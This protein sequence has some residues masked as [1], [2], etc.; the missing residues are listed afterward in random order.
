M[1]QIETGN[2]STTS[3]D[4]GGPY[5]WKYT[6]PAKIGLM[7]VHDYYYS[8]KGEETTNCYSSSAGCGDSWLHMSRNGKSGDVASEWFV[9]RHGWE[10]Y[11]GGFTAWWVSKLGGMSSSF[12]HNYCGVRP[13][14]Y[15]DS[16]KTKLSGSGTYSDPF[17][18]MPLQ[19]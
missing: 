7:Y 5:T 17:V 4:I 12:F 2:K 6:I 8:Y 1:Y 9:S 15:L 11:Y 10:N 13:V 19:N 14:F 16:S 18:A 3:G